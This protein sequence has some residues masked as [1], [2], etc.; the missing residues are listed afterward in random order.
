M[1]VLYIELVFFPGDLFYPPYTEV[2]RPYFF[3]WVVGIEAFNRTGVEHLFHQLHFLCPVRPFCI[4]VPVPSLADGM[5]SFGC[6]SLFRLGFCNC[7]SLNSE[8][9]LDFL[10]H[11]TRCTCPL[12]WS[13]LWNVQVLSLWTHNSSMTC[14]WDFILQDLCSA[15]CLLMGLHLPSF[16]GFI[17]FLEESWWHAWCKPCISSGGFWFTPGLIS[18]VHPPSS[19]PIIL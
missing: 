18:L 3:V 8:S 15:G 17:F 9:L 5:V 14:E 12:S 13:L 7:K 19:T 16:W 2:P 4:S 10:T 6:W 11:F 1:L